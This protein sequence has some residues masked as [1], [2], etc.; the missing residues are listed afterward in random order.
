MT[1]E[2]S[3]SMQ[4]QFEKLQARL[5][6]ERLQNLLFSLTDIHSPTGSAG[7]ACQ[8]LVDHLAAHGIPAKFLPFAGE[9]GAGLA[10]L[11]GAGPGANLLLYAPIDTHLEG[12]E[13]DY[14]WTGPAP[15]VDTQPRAVREGDWVYGL[16]SSNPKA[17]VATLAEIMICA[18]ESGW[19]LPGTLT[20][21]FADGGMPVDIGARQHGG[22]SNGIFHLLNRGGM[23]DFCIVMKPWN[24][25]Y[26]EEPGMA[27][28]KITVRGT[29]GYAGVPRGT[30]GFRSSIVPA[31]QLILDLEEWLPQYTARHTSGIIR[32]DGWISAVRAGWPGRPAFPSAATEI[33][34]DVRVN[35]RCP[36]A[37]V[38]AEFADF[39]A[40]M[41]DKHP[42][43]ECDWEMYGSVPGGSTDPE[44]W[45][46][47][48]ARR[49]WEEIEGRAYPEQPDLLGG[50]TDGSLLRA[51]GVPTAR[52]GWPWPAEG[53]P[54]EV[55]EGLG[56]MGATYIPDLLPCARKIMY[57]VVDTCSRP[58]Q[59]TVCTDNS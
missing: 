24:W 27:W 17:M 8:W 42:D 1:H 19:D 52:M 56:G 49:G 35:P 14:P 37:Q 36:P 28:F 39:M 21:G 12:D 48:S 6:P 44:N 2:L 45:I 31:A 13:S 46:I 26:H 22:M 10:T 43:L 3:Q 58:R 38:R 57:A 41:H 40:T 20:L 54:L 51:L 4:A 32:P 18:K 50:Q 33:Y 59:E 34:F 5:N 55:A 23:P 30:P 25:V 9:S 16:G 29:L 7:A 11:Q 15:T 53:S 47:Q